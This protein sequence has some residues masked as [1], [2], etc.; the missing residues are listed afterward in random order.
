MMKYWRNG[1]KF[2]TA[3]KK[4]FFILHPQIQI[5]WKHKQF[6]FFINFSNENSWVFSF[7]IYWNSTLVCLFF[8]IKFVAINFALLNSK[9][10]ANKITCKYWESALCPEKFVKF[11]I[12]SPEILFICKTRRKSSSTLC[13]TSYN[14]PLLCSFSLLVVS[15]LSNYK[16]EYIAKP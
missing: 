12:H 9:N 13:T 4:N 2:S 16:L 15:H 5:S 7:Y 10:F 8:D 3:N 11:V 1:K 14:F 6:F